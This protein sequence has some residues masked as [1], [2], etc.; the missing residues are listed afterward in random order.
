MQD[1]FKPYFYLINSNSLPIDL[2]VIFIILYTCTH[3]LI[4]V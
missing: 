3:T 4:V 1:N 2:F